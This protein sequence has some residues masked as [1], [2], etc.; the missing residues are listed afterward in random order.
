[1]YAFSSRSS[2]DSRWN[3]IWVRYMSFELIRPTCPGSIFNH[4][5]NS[6]HLI[7]ESAVKAEWRQLITRPLIQIPTPVFLWFFSKLT[8][9]Y[10]TVE[11]LRLKPTSYCRDIGRKHP[12]KSRQR[13]VTTIELQSTSSKEH[14]LF[15]VRCTCPETLEDIHR[16]SGNWREDRGEVGWD[17]RL[18]HYQWVHMFVIY[19]I[20]QCLS[21]VIG[22]S[23]PSLSLMIQMMKGQ[24]P[25]R[26][27]LKVNLLWLVNGCGIIVGH[28]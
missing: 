9:T 7:F 2:K 17:W 25:R 23:C 19:I 16:L 3:V 20:D 1:M 18:L 4:W 27:K 5:I 15:V 13:W 10:K 11:K 14:L 22:R 28:L 6:W 8:K 26:G 12:A 24:L 21:A